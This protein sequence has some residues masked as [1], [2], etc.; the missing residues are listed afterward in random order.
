MWLK[1]LEPTCLGILDLDVAVLFLQW[2]AFDFEYGASKV[3]IRRTRMDWEML[4]PE[5][6]TLRVFF[7]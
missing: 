5:I 4:S 7:L 3:S 1:A 6:W 2:F